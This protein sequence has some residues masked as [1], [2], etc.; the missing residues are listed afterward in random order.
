VILSI[1]YSLGALIDPLTNVTEIFS[2]KDGRAMSLVMSD[3]FD[4]EG[5]SFMSGHDDNFE[6]IEKPD[7]SNQ[8]I[9]YYNS[10]TEYVT[11]RNGSLTIITRAV[12]TSWVEWDGGQFKNV[13]RVKNYTSGILD[14]AYFSFVSS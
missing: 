6:A 4:E 7:D 5:R 13:L 12:K 9:Q 11:T 10:S 14:R 1:Q 2:H 3:E 8:A